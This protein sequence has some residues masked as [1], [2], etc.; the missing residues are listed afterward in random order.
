MANA[1][2]IHEMAALTTN[3]T[4]DVHWIDIALGI[5]AI[6]IVIASLFAA[7]YIPPMPDAHLYESATG[8]MLWPL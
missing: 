4:N 1:T 3:G 2:Q 8:M 6:V 5:A 7:Q